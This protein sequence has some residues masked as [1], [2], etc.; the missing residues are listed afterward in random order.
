MLNSALDLIFPPHCVCCQQTGDF[1]CQN[2]Y[3]QLEFY[4]QSVPIISRPDNLSQISI[5]GRHQAPLSQLIIACKY[6]HVKQIGS[7]L[8]KI[9]YHHLNLPKIDLVTY[10]PT[11]NKRLRQRGFNQSQVIALKL[12][13]LIDKPCLKLVNKSKAS[14]HQAKL[15]RKKRIQNLKSCFSPHI[16]LIKL[17]R[18]Q[19]LSVLLVDDVITTGTTLNQCARILRAAGIKEIK[20]LAISHQG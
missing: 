10:V 15:D 9:V 8:A 14:H 17:E 20:G 3:N 16:N 1:L 11:S 4:C 5:L 19:N 6:Q 7:F 12:S 18:R 13:Q 2:C